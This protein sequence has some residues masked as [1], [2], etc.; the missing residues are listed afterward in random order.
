[1]RFPNNVWSN[2]KL[3]WLDPAAG[4]GNFGLLIYYRLM[5]GLKS[6]IPDL[7][8]RSTH[9]LENMLYQVELKPTKRT[10]NKTSIW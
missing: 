7:K 6:K 4:V 9:I 3:K 2:T 10:K 1:M 8:K 5:N